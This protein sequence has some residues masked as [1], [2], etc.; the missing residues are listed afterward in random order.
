MLFGSG[1]GIV[2]ALGLL[3]A[4]SNGSG[5]TASIRFNTDGSITYT[6]SGGAGTGPAAWFNP[7]AGTPG[8]GYW[9]RCVVGS[10]A[11]TVNQAPTFTQ[12]SANRTFSITVAG[13]AAASAT[14][15][16]QISS[17]A[18]GVTIVSNGTF[19]ISCN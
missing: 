17:D 8:N 4:N 16:F 5:V 19:S 14:G 12:L 18:G 3:S 11:L 6:T 10:G 2:P 1:G 13:V 9:I 7:P 15:T